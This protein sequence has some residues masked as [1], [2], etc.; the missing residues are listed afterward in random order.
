M[1]QQAAAFYE[2]V[3]DAYHAL[4]ASEPERFRIIDGNA[5]VDVVAERVWAAVSPHV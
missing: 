5:G 3:R 4:A 1:E 2:K